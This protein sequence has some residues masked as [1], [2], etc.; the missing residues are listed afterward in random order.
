MTIQHPIDNQ[1]VVAIMGLHPKAG[2]LSVYATKTGIVA[3]GNWKED[4]R[5]SGLSGYALS[6]YKERTKRNLAYIY[7]YR[8]D[9]R[10]AVVDAVLVSRNPRGAPEES[11]IVSLTPASKDRW[12]EA[13]VMVATPKSSEFHLWGQEPSSPV[14]VRH[15]QGIPLRPIVEC[16]WSMMVTGIHKCDL[17]T[18]FDD[19]IRVYPIA[20]DEFFA[21]TTESAI[22]SFINV[23]VEKQCPPAA[24][25]KPSTSLDIEEMFKEVSPNTIAP[26]DESV[27][28]FQLLRE[29]RH[30]D[31][32]QRLVKE[33]A[34]NGSDLDDLL[35]RFRLPAPRKFRLLG[36]PYEQ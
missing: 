21:K 10:A 22:E 17:V 30:I 5:K 36:D 19:E 12:A 16:A 4:S 28:I 35:D 20:H 29:L 9:W 32:V 2:A 18:L 7:T 15:H 24:D 1:D 3:P 26:T 6:L 11:A 14:S 23:F 34:V 27:S 25:Y 13:L 31:S 8:H 33:G